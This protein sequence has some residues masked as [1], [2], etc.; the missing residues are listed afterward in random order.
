[1]KTKLT[2]ELLNEVIAA[3]SA[4]KALQLLY[5]YIPHAPSPGRRYNK[6]QEILNLVDA[7]HTSFGAGHCLGL[8]ID[9]G[10]GAEFDRILEVLDLIGA[11]TASAYLKEGRDA[12]GGHIPQD[13]LERAH[14]S[15]SKDRALC[16]IDRKYSGKIGDEV[17]VCFTK[18]IALNKE[19][20][21][22]DLNVVEP[23][24]R[25]PTSGY[26]QCDSSSP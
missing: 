25:S 3:P 24:K 4:D 23:N 18:W 6:T 11:S 14:L 19:M 15:I 26:R 17:A 10:T 5:R 8:I 7:I 9:Y 22:A 1:M 12:C 2:M 13:E 21:L 16:A 20:V